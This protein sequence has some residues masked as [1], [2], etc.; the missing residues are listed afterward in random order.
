MINRRSSC[1]VT[2]LN[3]KL[4]VT[5]GNDGTLCLNSTERYDPVKNG[6]ENVTSM[7]SRRC[8]HTK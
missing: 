4:Y 8:V 3:N 5:G 2:A 1:G 7:H 6:W